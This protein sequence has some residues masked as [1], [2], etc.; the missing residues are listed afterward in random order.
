MNSYAFYVIGL[1]IVLNLRA[2]EGALFGLNI[3]IC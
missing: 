2:V 3:K 1:Q